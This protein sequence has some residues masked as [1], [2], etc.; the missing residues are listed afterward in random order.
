MFSK[1][2]GASW[3]YDTPSFFIHNTIM[4]SC[5]FL[6]SPSSGTN[7]R[8]RTHVKG[9]SAEDYYKVFP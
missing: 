8:P 1:K 9:R 6:E 3:T 7:F 2:K 5:I 4:L